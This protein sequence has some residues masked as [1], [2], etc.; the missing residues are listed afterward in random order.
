M[1]R[2]VRIAVGPPQRRRT[3]EEGLSLVVDEAGHG[4]RPLLLVHGFTGSKEDFADHLDALAAAGWHVVAPDLRGHGQSDKPGGEH[5]YT[6]D[7]FAGDLLALADRLGWERFSLVGHSMGG[8]VAQLVALGAPERLDSLILMDTG[9]GPVQ[10]DPALARG[11]AELVRSAG[12][13]ALAD[14]LGTAGGPDE[15]PAAARL[16][17]LRPDL[18]AEWDLR[19]RSTSAAMY[20][21]MALTM[22]AQDDRLERLRGLEVPTLVLVGAQDGPFLADSHRMSEA[23]PGA[24]LAVVPDAGHSPQRENAAAWRTAIVS[25]LDAV[26]LTEEGRAG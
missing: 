9:H 5:D 8:M 1:T 23:I 2:S 21:A 11:A 16:R 6:L 25:F 19:L 4:G 15:P 3:G 13:G 7:L 22:L 12:M 24:R 14:I 17:R 18:V 10:I 26:A 20:A